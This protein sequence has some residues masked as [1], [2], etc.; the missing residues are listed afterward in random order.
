MRT[1]DDDVAGQLS[2]CTHAPSA[3][4]NS[5]LPAHTTPNNRHLYARPHSRPSWLPSRKTRSPSSLYSIDMTPRQKWPR[6]TMQVLET[7]LTPSWRQ[8]FRRTIPIL[9]AIL[10]GPVSQKSMSRRILKTKCDGI[11]IAK[12]SATGL[13]AMTSVALTRGHDPGSGVTDLWPRS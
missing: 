3:C 13:P 11:S 8:K 10:V 12:I 4:S 9:L 1:E 2:R 6:A 5:S 7:R